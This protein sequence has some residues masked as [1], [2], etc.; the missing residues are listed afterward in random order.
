MKTDWELIEKYLLE[1]HT[2][3]IVHDSEVLLVIVKMVQGERS[4][5]EK[6]KS[7]HEKGMRTV[8]LTLCV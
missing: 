1:L 3:C 4:R 6:T 7:R 8:T 2:F 5:E